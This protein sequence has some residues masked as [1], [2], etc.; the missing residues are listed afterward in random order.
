MN[1]FKQRHRRD[2]KSSREQPTVPAVTES[3]EASTTDISTTEGGLPASTA[4][5]IAEGSEVTGE[6]HVTGR[7]DVH[8]TVHGSVSCDATVYVAP[9]GRL[10]GDVLAARIEVAGFMEGSVECSAVVIADG[11]MLRGD[12]ASDTFSIENGGIFEGQSTRRT[13]DNVTK[14]QKQLHSH[15]Q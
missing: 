14:L 13:P 7:I 2:Q 8:G 9:A 3:S 5:I 6:L 4:T 15:G 10:K 12:V 1:L 11:G